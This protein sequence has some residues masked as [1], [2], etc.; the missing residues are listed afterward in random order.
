M[1]IEYRIEGGR[2][3]LGKQGV[4]GSSVSFRLVDRETKKQSYSFGPEV[5]KHD[6]MIEVIEH[7]DGLDFCCKLC[8]ILFLETLVV[9]LPRKELPQEMH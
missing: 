4:K 7:L 9:S 1:L 8:W 5:F 2:G 6:S 3:A